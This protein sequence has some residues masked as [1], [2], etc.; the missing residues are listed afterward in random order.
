MGRYARGGVKLT[1]TPSRNRVKFITLNYKQN[2]KVKFI[3][4]N[5]KQNEKVYAIFLKLLDIAA[6]LVWIL[7]SPV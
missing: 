2:E 7:H 5:Y 1:P 6:P 4:L 3:T